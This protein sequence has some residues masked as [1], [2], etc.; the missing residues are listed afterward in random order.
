MGKDL[1]RVVNLR[2][3]MKFIN[4][5][6]ALLVSGF[7]VYTRFVPEDSGFVAANSDQG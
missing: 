7:F 5:L 4:Q 6:L 2:P 1:Q 3:Y